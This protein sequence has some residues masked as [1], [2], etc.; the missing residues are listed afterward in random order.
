MSPPW[1]LVFLSIFAFGR[2]HWIQP[3]QGLEVKLYLLRKN[4]IYLQN[5]F[6]ILLQERLVYVPI[7]L[8]VSVFIHSFTS[9]SNLYTCTSQCEF[10]GIY[11]V[12]YAIIQYYT[13]YCV[14]QIAPVWPLWAPS[15]GFV[16][17]WHTTIVCFIEQALTFCHY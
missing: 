14:V 4:Y 9:F 5:V 12:F 16:T 17:F 10:K 3:T 6:E 13:V 2:R 1:L 8:L 7:C 11:F 15:L